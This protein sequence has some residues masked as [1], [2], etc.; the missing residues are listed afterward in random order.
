MTWYR[1]A[2]RC[3]WSALLRCRGH[4]NLS[5]C[6]WTEPRQISCR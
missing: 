5:L 1:V 6:R 3:A 2:Q 4:R